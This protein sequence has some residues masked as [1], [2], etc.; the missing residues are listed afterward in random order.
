L[1]DGSPNIQS[2]S[3]LVLDLKSGDIVF[4][5]DADTLRPVASL[6]K[7][8]GA[9]V[10]H[11]ECSLPE[12]GM[13]EM[14]AANRDAAR[15]GD[16][17]KLTTG[18]SY[19]HS[20]LMHAALM[21]SDNRALPA[22]G[23]A[24]GMDTAKFAERMTERARRLG[25]LFTQ[26]K[27]PN[28]LSPGNVS[29]AREMIVIL[30]EALR[31]KALTDIMNTREHT[32]TGHKDGR[33]RALRIRN[34]DRLLA[35]NLAEILGGKTGYTDLARY[36]L[37]VAARTK[38]GREIGMIFLGAEGRYTRFADFTRIVRW[39]EP[40]PEEKVA[41]ERRQKHNRKSIGPA[42][43][44]PATLKVPFAPPPGET[45]AATGGE[46]SW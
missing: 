22:L 42:N 45:P 27:E 23:E 29:T 11:E 43:V 12:N 36:C 33:S 37:A 44:Q 14:T 30:K 2:Q 6:S 25:L 28:G 38:G 24:C 19:S 34:T 18:W 1:S 31:V 8:M 16:K 3:A 40:T 17:T 10:I 35:K 32:I 7:L 9:L 39:L 46:F 4:A 20:D 13:H 21:R 15:G 41:I 26:F 5:K